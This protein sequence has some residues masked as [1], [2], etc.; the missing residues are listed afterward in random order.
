MENTSLQIPRDLIDPIIEAHVS[1]AVLSALA[2]KQGLMQRVVAQTLSAKVDSQGRKS[3]YNDAKPWIQWLTEECIREAVKKALQEAVAKN[4][5]MVRDA[6][7]K[8]LQKK[9]SPLV[10]QLVSGMTSAFTNPSNLN[11][12]LNVVLEE[13]KA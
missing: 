9:N 1:A 11:W 5:E 2:D 4:E 13:R 3:D 7:V 12:R 10:R 6:I 8:E